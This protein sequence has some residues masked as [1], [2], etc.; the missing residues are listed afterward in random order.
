MGN[1]QTFTIKVTRPL[2]QMPSATKK[3]RNLTNNVTARLNFNS[4]QGFSP[5]FLARVRERERIAKEAQQ[6]EVRRIEK[7]KELPN[8]VKQQQADEDLIL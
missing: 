3:L 4:F 1:L 8:G 2:A 5:E 7:E 6:Q